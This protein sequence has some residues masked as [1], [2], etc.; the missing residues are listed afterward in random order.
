MF[1]GEKGA[2]VIGERRGRNDDRDGGQKIGGL[3]ARKMIDERGFERRMKST[4]HNP[5]HSGLFYATRSP[6]P[7]ALHCNRHKPNRRR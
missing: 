3:D 6:V 1:D 5:Q 2:K 4:G 7:R